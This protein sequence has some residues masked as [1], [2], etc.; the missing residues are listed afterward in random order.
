M[1]LKATL[2]YSEV[3]SFCEL[4]TVLAVSLLFTLSTI[5]ST[6]LMIIYQNSYHVNGV[7][8]PLAWEGN[9]GFITFDFD[10]GLVSVKVLVTC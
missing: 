5:I 6:L 4:D 1:V 3:V 7:K 2:D 10:H 9:P 8:S